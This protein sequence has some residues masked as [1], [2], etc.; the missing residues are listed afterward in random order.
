M[1]S[2]VNSVIE[3][4]LLQQASEN[5]WGSITDGKC[6]DEVVDVKQFNTKVGA[7]CN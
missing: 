2:E 7:S 5:G 1:C 6:E 3:E 4:L